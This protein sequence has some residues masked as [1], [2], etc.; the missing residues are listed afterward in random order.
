MLFDLG[1]DPGEMHNLADAGTEAIEPVRELFAKTVFGISETWYIELSGGGEQ[2]MFDLDISSRTGPKTGSVYIAHVFDSAGR[3]LDIESLGGSGLASGGISIRDLNLSS[4]VTVAFKVE[5]ERTPLEIDMRIDGQPSTDAVYL[6][7]ALKNPDAIPF[8]TDR[9]KGESIPADLPG[10]RPRGPYC[11]IWR[12]GKNLGEPT[13][14]ELGE[15][16]ESEL[17]SVGYLQ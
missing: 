17:R 5:P 3:M 8:T 2:H 11:L 14:F 16:I 15:G 6:G 9:R 12:S 13:V 7:A 10:E 1:T 4:K